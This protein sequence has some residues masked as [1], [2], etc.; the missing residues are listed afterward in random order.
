LF[1]LVILLD[2]LAFALLMRWS[3]NGSAWNDRHK[4]AVVCGLLAFFIVFDALQD[5]EASFT[6]LSIVAACTVWG[7]WRVRKNT[8]ARYEIN[9]NLLEHSVGIVILLLKLQKS[10][11]SE[12]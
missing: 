6:G 2:G 8:W 1:G 4:L 5:L 3:G 7:L 9:E 10:T 12:S 11:P